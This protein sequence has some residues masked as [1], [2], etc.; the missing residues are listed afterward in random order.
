MINF[1]KCITNKE[2]YGSFY[3]EAV[4]IDVAFG[5][6]HWFVPPMGIM[7]SSL[8]DNNRITEKNI[9]IALSN[10]INAK[11]MNITNIIGYF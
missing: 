9:G 1:S 7:M 3:E 6:D 2:I 11:V 10:I 4:H 5:V 8:L